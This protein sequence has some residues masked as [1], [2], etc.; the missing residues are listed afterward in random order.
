MKEPIVYK[1]VSE[2]DKVFETLAGTLEAGF[3][4]ALGSLTQAECF[5]RCTTVEKTGLRGVLESFAAAACAV[6]VRYQTG[7]VGNLLFVCKVADLAKLG[8]LLAGS[9]GTGTETLSPELMESCM[10]FFTLS[11]GESNKLF[12]AKHFQVSSSD[13]ELL[14]PDGNT[15][16]LE[17]LHSTYESALCAS[18]RMGVEPMLDCPLCLLADS[19]LLES[20]ITMLPDSA[21]K[22]AVAPADPQKAGP[23]KQKPDMPVTAEPE[24]EAV[25]ARPAKTA[26]EKASGNWNIDLLLDVELPV[27]VSFGECQMPLKDV[28][29]LAAGAVI[30]LE[31][32]VNDPVTIIVNEKPI[33]RGEVVMVD[34][35]YGVRIT[36]VESTADRI[37]SLA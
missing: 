34:G 17:P 11:A 5:S 18:Y 35:N 8:E 29:K 22:P 2:G 33:A 37:R 23:P 31:K 1:G 12:S 30:E 32:S 15:A 10:R 21:P 14:N 6:E 4:A 9:E 24:V 16:S 3:S 28:L 20:L 26:P 25:P 36:E 19:Q 27:A 7:L 13:P